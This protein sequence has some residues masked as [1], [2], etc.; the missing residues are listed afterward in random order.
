MSNFE[1]PE[2]CY[3]FH[4]VVKCFSPLNCCLM[5]DSDIKVLTFQTVRMNSGQQKRSPQQHRK[6]SASTLWEAGR[7][8]N[9]TI[10]SCSSWNPR[11]FSAGLPITPA[12]SHGVSLGWGS[13]DNLL[14]PILWRMGF[15]GAAV[16][17]VCSE[18]STHCDSRVCSKCILAQ[19]KCQATTWELLIK[20]LFKWKIKYKYLPKLLYWGD[21]YTWATARS[22]NNTTF[23]WSLT[24]FFQGVAHWNWLKRVI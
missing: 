10:F 19:V 15:L 13:T 20:E 22:C 16:S 2:H 1:S 12:W 8:P 6:H 24:N 17:C 11:V 18:P 23:L 21:W 5:L 3:D 4:S 14:L 7:L 9:N